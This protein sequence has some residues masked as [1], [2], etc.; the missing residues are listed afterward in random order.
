MGEIAQ[1]KSSLFSDF[2]RTFTWDLTVDSTRAFQLDLP[3]HGMRQ[4]PNE[5]TCPNKHTYSLITYLRTGLTTIGTFCK[6]GVVTTI[7]VRYRGRL[8]LRVPADKKLDPVD[9][10]LSVGPEIS[11]ELLVIFINMLCQ[12]LNSK[13]TDCK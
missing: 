1:T 9:Y 10:K 8:V 7:L 2:N 4:I 11:G 3:K 5:E 13:F 12:I 6:G